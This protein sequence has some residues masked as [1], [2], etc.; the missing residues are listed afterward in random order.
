MVAYHRGLTRLV[1]LGA[2]GFG[3]RSHFDFSGEFISTQARRGRWFDYIPAHEG[4]M[5]D[6]GAKHIYFKTMTH[7]F[8]SYRAEMRLFM[9]Q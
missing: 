3:R 2:A 6:S 4:R 1:G 5:Q 9:A 8:K 7:C